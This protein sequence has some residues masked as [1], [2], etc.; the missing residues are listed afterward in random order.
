MSYLHVHVHVHK[1][2]NNSKVIFCIAS[3][4]VK[5]LIYNIR[6]YNQQ[7]DWQGGSYKLDY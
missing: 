5:I 3:R 4:K 6:T 1:V 2:I 7:N